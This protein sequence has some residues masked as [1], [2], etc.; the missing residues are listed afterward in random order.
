VREDE[1]CAESWVITAP[2]QRGKGLATAAVSLWAAET[3]K[4]EKIPFY[5]HALTNIPSARLAGKLGLIPIFE[6][7][8]LEKAESGK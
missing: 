4:T 6:E 8:V 5:S 2:E 1:F 3:L 7:V